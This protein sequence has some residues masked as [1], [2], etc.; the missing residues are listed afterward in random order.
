LAEFET[1]IEIVL[2][3]EG[4]FQRDPHDK[5]NWTGGEVGLGELRGTN[6]GISAA[7]YPDEDIEGLTEERAKEIYFKEYW[8]CGY[9]QIDD[10]GV[11]NKV[12]DLAVN[13]E[14]Y[15]KHGPAVRILQ[16]AIVSCGKIINIDGV[17]G[18]GTILAANSIPGDE[19]L[20]AIK[21][22]AVEHYQRIVEKNPHLAAFLGGWKVRAIA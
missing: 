19:L 18:P 16:S 22:E 12:L 14:R 10:Q 3:H 9:G 7:S 13:M 4:G 5:G 15:G 6:R 21:R 11:A 20:A 8:S 17:F 2:K 1:A